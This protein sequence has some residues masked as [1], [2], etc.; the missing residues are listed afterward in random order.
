MLH[1]PSPLI[2]LHRLVPVAAG[3]AARIKIKQSSARVISA[4]EKLC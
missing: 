4:R 3:A 1:L 2:A